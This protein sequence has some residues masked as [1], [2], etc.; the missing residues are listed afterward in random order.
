MPILRVCPYCGGDSHLL[1]VL[2]GNAA[3]GCVKD[4]ECFGYVMRNQFPSAL[5]DIKV[6]GWN[7][8][9]DHINRDLFPLVETAPPSNL[10]K[11]WIKDE[12]LDAEER[13]N[14]IKKG[15]C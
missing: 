14:R 11:K 6:E 8:R 1:D 10:L 5:T 12:C 4:S 2:D 15:R 13:Y 3:I 9:W 7:R